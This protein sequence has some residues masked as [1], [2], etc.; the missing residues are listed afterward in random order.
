VV[1][2]RRAIYSVA[3]RDHDNTLSLCSHIEIASITE[4]LDLTA[5][6]YGD[7]LTPKSTFIAIELLQDIL[8]MEAP[9]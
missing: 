7:L 5:S 8:P 9:S 2:S 3:D 6:R 1:P 4:V